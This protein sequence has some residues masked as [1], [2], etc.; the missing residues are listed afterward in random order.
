MKRKQIEDESID[1][2]EIPDT[3][4]S[5]SSAGEPQAEEFFTETPEEKKLRLTKE[6]LAQL[7]RDAPDAVDE[8]LRNDYEEEI[9][10]RF[11]AAAFAAPDPSD[12]ERFRAHE[13]GRPTALALGRG[14]AFSAAKD[15]SIVRVALTGPRKRT[16]IS[17]GAGVAVLCIAHDPATGALATGDAAGGIALWDSERGGLLTEFDDVRFRHKR[18]VT[19]LALDGRQKQLFSCSCDCTV[20]VWDTETGG[21]LTTL[22]GHQMEPFSLD[23]C[24]VAVTSGADRTLRMWKH[25]EEKQYV[26]SGSAIK[27]PIDCVSM[28]NSECC[29][30]GSQDG[31]LCLWD[32][33]KKKPLSTV[34]NAHGE[35]FWI[36]AVAALR[37]RRFFATG[38]YNGVVKFWSVSEDQKITF[39]FEVPVTGYINDIEF[40]RDGGFV[41]V[42]VSQEQRCGRW[43]SNIQSA[44]QG[45][46]IIKLTEKAS[47]E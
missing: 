3:S 20:K 10:K 16:V 31:V 28:F 8:R 12:I 45:V 36:T 19:G 44:R 27:A 41:A 18:A 22:Y 9:G 33:S 47:N 37:F 5:E 21:C 13:R 43:L 1:S 39:C 23:F 40:S 29:V 2:D 15:G 26:Y 46:H 34:R 38:S 24:G 11:D 35:G 30:T 25:E 14:C 42:Q 6:Y 17:S 7:E 32:L 4:D